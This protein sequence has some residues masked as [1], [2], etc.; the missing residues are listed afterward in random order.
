MDNDF[1]ENGYLGKQ[2]EG[3]RNENMNNFQEYFSFAYIANQFFNKHKFDFDFKETRRDLVISSSFA[4]ILTSFQASILLCSFGLINEA[5]V[6]LRSMMEATFVMVAC[7]KNDDFHENYI[8][9]FHAERLRVVK[10]IHSKNISDFLKKNIPQDDLNKLKDKC[11]NE[12]INKIQVKELAEKANM[13]HYY[14]VPYW[15]LS[16]A[17]HVSPK[18]AEKYINLVADG[19]GYI[20]MWPNPNQYSIKNI[21]IT[22]SDLLFRSLTTLYEFYNK[23]QP[24]D[25]SEILE[26]FKA[27]NEDNDI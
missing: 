16:L 11:K 27:I 14:Y 10:N 5:E 17:T 1:D 24:E 4:R 25:F 13:E 2:A 9:S 3:W 23:T 12:Q 20:E 22:G 7:C 18:S 6:V 26:R 15:S 21:I 8:K 19:E